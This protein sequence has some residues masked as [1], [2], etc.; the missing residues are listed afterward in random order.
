MLACGILFCGH[1]T[2]SKHFHELVTPHVQQTHFKKTNG[3]IKRRNMLDAASVQPDMCKPRTK[4]SKTMRSKATKAK[5]GVK[6]GIDSPRL[7]HSQMDSGIICFHSCH[8]RWVQLNISILDISGINIAYRLQLG[9]CTSIGG[10]MC[11]PIF[12]VYYFHATM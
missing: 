6:K 2:Q 12:I 7:Q 10:R 1:A 3:Q 8:D 4:I 5:L 9:W 11:V